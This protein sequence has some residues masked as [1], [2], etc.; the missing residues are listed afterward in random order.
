MANGLIDSV[1]VPETPVKSGEEYVYESEFDGWLC[2]YAET[3]SSTLSTPILC[4][5]RDRPFPTVL[6]LASNNTATVEEGGQVAQWQ[7]LEKIVR[8][9]SNGLFAPMALFHFMQSLCS[10]REPPLNPSILHYEQQVFSE[11][12]K[13]EQAIALQYIYFSELKYKIDK[14]SAKPLDCDL[15]AGC[16]VEACRLVLE[17]VTPGRIGSA[18]QTQL[19][20]PLNIFGLVDKINGGDEESVGRRMLTE[21]LASECDGHTTPLDTDCLISAM[22]SLPRGDGWDLLSQESGTLLYSESTTDLIHR[23]Y[24]KRSESACDSYESPT[25]EPT[26][27][28]ILT[29][30]EIVERFM[31]VFIN[32]TL[33]L[34]Q[35]G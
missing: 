22:Q 3:L 35:D 32:D 33:K 30:E 20:W 29:D 18:L 13:S 2:S 5:N 11:L 6:S 7:E 19:N 31:Y 25:D 21:L 15:F 23:L 24:L 9:R 4:H 34:L 16:V 14:D 26:T 8:H 28:T 12:K 1:F 10:Q 27:L 17:G